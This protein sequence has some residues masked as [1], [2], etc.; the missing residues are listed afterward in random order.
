MLTRNLAGGLVSMLLGTVYLYFAYGI[1]ASALADTMGAGGVPRVYGWLMVMLGAIL[2]L[3]SI[4]AYLRNPEKKSLA[5]EW[6]GQGLKTLKA[7]GLVCFGIAYLLIVNTLGYLLS[8]AL[9]LIA[10]S[11]VSGSSDGIPVA[12]NRYR[13]R[14]FSLDNLCSGARCS[15]AFRCSKSFR[16]L[17][18][19]RRTLPVG[20]GVNLWKRSLP[21]LPIFLT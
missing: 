3:Q 4:V 11:A 2:S 5:S 15:H 7:A 12:L 21:P 18:C 16:Y 9:L 14:N 8:I 10:R 17:I 20:T 19:Q 13:W 6:Q 1:R